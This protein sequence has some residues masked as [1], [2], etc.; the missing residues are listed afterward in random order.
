MLGA[1]P[2]V[3]M[4]CAMGTCPHNDVAFRWWESSIRVTER[5]ML[6]HQRS[7]KDDGSRTCFMRHLLSIVTTVEHVGSC[8][9]IK[10]KLGNNTLFT[11]Q[12]II[13]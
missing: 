8:V 12:R 1:G 4:Q 11:E 6:H 5:L 2:W 7:S 3:L 10:A 13:L 9:R